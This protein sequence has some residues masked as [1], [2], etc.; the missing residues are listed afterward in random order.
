MLWLWLNG[1]WLAGLRRGHAAQGGAAQALFDVVSACW[2]AL[3][4]TGLFDNYPWLT[5]SWPAAMLLGLLA[6]ALIASLRAA[7]PGNGDQDPQ[8]NMRS[9]AKS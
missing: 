2:L 6:G 7:T 1:A 4:V 3:F 9:A 5:S 8:S